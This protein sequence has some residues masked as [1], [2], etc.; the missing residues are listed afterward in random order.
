[1]RKNRSNLFPLLI[2]LDYLTPILITIGI[3][4]VLFVKMALI[5]PGPKSETYATFYSLSS[6]LQNYYDFK[7]AWKPR[8]LS[9]GLSAFTAHV[10][11][12]LLA[13]ASVPIVKT[14]SELTIALWTS[15]WFT[16]NFA[17]FYFLLQKAFSFLYFR[18]L[19]WNFIWLSQSNAYGTKG[20]PSGFSRTIL[21]FLI[22][23]SIY[24]KEILVDLC[25][26][27]I[28]C[29]VQRNYPYSLYCISVF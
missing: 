6:G 16:F 15:G 11:Y 7:T 26:N 24:E 9:T 29:W 10:S 1:M 23:A 22:S 25:V 18:Y 28:K 14:S 21:F 4:I 8:I 5:S 2:I 17:G 3:A 19:C 20:L 12:W 27:P 13:K